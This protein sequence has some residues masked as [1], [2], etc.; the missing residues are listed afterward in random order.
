MDSPDS[1]VAAPEQ[2][3]RHDVSGASPLRS[4][5]KNA[6]SVSVFAYR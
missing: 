3:L 4:L 1:V 6:V 5:K 2:P